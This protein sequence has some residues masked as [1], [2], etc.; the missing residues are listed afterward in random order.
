M[1]CCSEHPTVDS[2]WLVLLFNPLP[3]LYLPWFMKQAS[4]RRTPRGYYGQG[5][6]LAALLLAALTG[7]QQFPAAL[8]TVW[9]MLALRWASFAAKQA[10]GRPASPKG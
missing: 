9:G 7:V 8:W 5:V 3:L 10:A 2:N 6:L 1:F 4:M